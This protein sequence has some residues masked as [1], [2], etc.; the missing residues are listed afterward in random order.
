[1][2]K[3]PHTDEQIATDAM[4]DIYGNV[5]GARGTWAEYDMR[6][7]IQRILRA[8]REAKAAAALLL[9]LMPFAAHAQCIGA[10]YRLHPEPCK[11][12]DIGFI[13]SPRTVH[14]FQRLT[15]PEICDV[16][17]R[18]GYIKH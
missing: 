10:D 1:M 3:E 4:R 6:Y 7:V 12:T 18:L 9:F 8:I 13:V 15:D 5:T 14:F 11:A 2:A 17:N 16:I